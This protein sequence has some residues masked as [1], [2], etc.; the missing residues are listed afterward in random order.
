MTEEKLLEISYLIA[1]R[2]KDLS[3]ATGCVIADKDNNILSVG[4]NGLPRGMEY[5]NNQDKLQRPLKYSYT[6]HAERNAIYN[7]VNM[8]VSLKG[9]KII[10]AWTPCA[11]CARAIIQSG[12]KEVIIDENFPATKDIL[13][14]GDSVKASIE[15][16]KECEVNFRKIKSVYDKYNI[17]AKWQGEILELDINNVNMEDEKIKDYFK[18]KYS[19][20]FKF[21]VN[22]NLTESNFYLTWDSLYNEIK[23]ITNNEI[24][25]FKTKD[26]YFKIIQKEKITTL[27]LDDLKQNGYS[28]YSKNK[29]LKL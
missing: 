25:I 23:K 24:E 9:S 19:I 8:G 14:W 28:K 6:E 21:E 11:D 4:Y 29:K 22:E 16:F 10:L 27:L 2:S 7:A 20:D 26:N 17:L 12:I 13:H 5:E 15:M 1:R 18:I 3:T